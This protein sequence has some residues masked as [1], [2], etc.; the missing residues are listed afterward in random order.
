MRA[1]D[2][3]VWGSWSPSFTISD[4]D[5]IADGQTLEL[6]SAFAG[7]LGFG[8][9]TGVLQLDQSLSFSGTVAG[10]AGQDRIDLAD[11]AFGS[12][13]SLTYQADSAGGGGT[14][15]VCDGLHAASVMLLGQYAAASFAL[16]ADAHGGIVVTTAE[17]QPV[18]LHASA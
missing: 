7:R 6:P 13:T 14:L 12:H 3:N 2:G 15:S 16:A 10:F 1:N 11:I 8:G 17:P 9:Q 18:D 5:T 4:P